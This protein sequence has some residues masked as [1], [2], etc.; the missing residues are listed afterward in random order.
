MPP[1]SV[2]KHWPGR[3]LIVKVQGELT[4][5]TCD[6][7]TEALDVL[8]DGAEES[9]IAVD[10]SSLTFFDSSAVRCLVIAHR[11]VKSQGGE[12]VIL[13]AGPLIQRFQRLGLLQVLPVTATLPE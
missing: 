8:A 6:E 9:C 7:L 1:L 4:F 12:F 3:W 13:D 2:T 5:Q 11:R 10:A